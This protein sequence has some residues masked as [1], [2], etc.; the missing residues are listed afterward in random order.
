MS[1][2]G[3]EY[4]ARVERLQELM[5]KE[6]AG[7]LAVFGNRWR[8]GFIRYLSGYRPPG[9]HLS[10]KVMMLIP[11]EGNPVMCVTPESVAE[12]VKTLPRPCDLKVYKNLLT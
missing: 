5:R 6:G 7:H 10:S 11:S 8:N 3:S 2:D 9:A 4:G 12:H 1:T